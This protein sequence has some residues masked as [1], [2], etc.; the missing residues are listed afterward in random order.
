VA[1]DSSNRIVVAGLS[2]SGLLSESKAVNSFVVMRF[3]KDGHD[4]D[5]DFSGDGKAF[6]GFFKDLGDA[7]LVV[8]GATM[9][10]PT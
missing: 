2:W 9:R 5:S 6:G 4:L 8:I 1:I 3:D 7:R 10:P